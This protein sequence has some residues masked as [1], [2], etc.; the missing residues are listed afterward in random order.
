MGPESAG[1]WR[2]RRLEKRALRSIQDLAQLRRLKADLGLR[3]LLT[4][5]VDTVVYVDEQK[6]PRPDC[7]D[8]H[9]DLDLSV[10]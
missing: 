2:G 5:S 9:A 6:M 4:E 7:T 10:A 1:K 8:A 3:C